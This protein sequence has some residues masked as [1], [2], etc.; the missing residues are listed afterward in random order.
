MNRNSIANLKQNL[1][2]LISIILL[3]TCKNREKLP[4]DC[5]SKDYY[6][7]VRQS[8]GL[9]KINEISDL[10]FLIEFNSNDSWGI[11]N[12]NVQIS[13]DEVG[14]ILNSTEFLRMKPTKN[15]IQLSYQKE[16]VLNRL[17]L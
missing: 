1:F 6:Y 5:N 7:T 15:L 17:I 3:T 9:Q 10:D 13:Q 4:E 14:Y 16:S 2:F 11:Y 8:I 12:I